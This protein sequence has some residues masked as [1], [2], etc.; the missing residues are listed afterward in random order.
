MA[1]MAARRMVYFSRAGGNGRAIPDVEGFLP[2]HTEDNAGEEDTSRTAY[3]DLSVHSCVSERLRSFYKEDLFTDITL[4]AN[5]VFIRA[6]KLVLAASSTFFEAQ[7]RY[8]KNLV[9]TADNEIF[10]QCDGGILKEII[11]YVY[12]GTITIT[13]SNIFDLMELQDY[14]QIAS[15]RN[16]I[17]HFIRSQMNDSDVFVESLKLKKIAECFRYYDLAS[18]L[19]LHIRKK[20]FLL[21]PKEEFLDI[22]LELFLECLDSNFLVYGEEDHLLI[23]MCRW[24]CFEVSRF[25]AF[26]DLINYVQPA[27]IKR[28]N[29]TKEKALAVV[30]SYPDLRFWLDGWFC[31]SQHHRLSTPGSGIS[32]YRTTMKPVLMSLGGVGEGMNNHDPVRTVDCIISWYSEKWRPMIPTVND[33]PPE[34]IEVPLMLYPRLRPVVVCD[35]TNVYVTGGGTNCTEMYNSLTNK[36][37]QLPDVPYNADASSAALSVLDG[38]LYLVVH[39]TIDPTQQRRS[40]RFMVLHKDS[41]SWHDLESPNVRNTSEFN[42][43]PSLVSSLSSI[44][45][46]TCGETYEE[47]LIWRYDVGLNLWSVVGVQPLVGYNHICSCTVYNHLIFIIFNNSILYSYNTITQQWRKKGDRQPEDFQGVATLYNSFISSKL[48]CEIV[49]A[50]ESNTNSMYLFSLTG[51][52]SNWLNKRRLYSGLGYFNL[53]LFEPPLM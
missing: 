1:N 6:H 13:R 46:L 33:N 25:P 40:F 49:L 10:L 41:K 30:E 5:N 18:D 26:K 3:N 15:L 31:G 50:D 29:E 39:N 48:G 53:G 52:R 36:W 35:G 43:T 16:L 8:E 9:E 20:F 19:F 11:D 27:F 51:R 2:D 17:V 24:T 4:K 14:L 32:R 45:L 47:K 12:F 38:S 22:P 37:L 42:K 7:F 21:L 28:W 34:Y 44:Y 23:G